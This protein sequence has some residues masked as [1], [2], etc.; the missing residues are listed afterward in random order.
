MLHG[1]GS[2][3]TLLGLAVEGVKAASSARQRRRLAV[4]A[5]AGAV[6]AFSLLIALFLLG[7]AVFTGLSQ[8]MLLPWAA[9]LAALAMLAISGAAAGLAYRL[10]P[11]PTADMAEVLMEMQAKVEPLIRQNPGKAVLAAAALGGLTALFM[12]R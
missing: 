10:R 8:F 1:Q 6:G 12:R 2:A 11:S 3:L 7:W 5:V 4:V 9:V